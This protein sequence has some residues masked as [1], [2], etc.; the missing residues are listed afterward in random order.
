MEEESVK[1]HYSLP[2]G[3]LFQANSLG[4]RQPFTYLFFE[5]E[6]VVGLVNMKNL[7]G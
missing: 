7:K 6:K 4:E 5:I 1:F 2:V 3:K